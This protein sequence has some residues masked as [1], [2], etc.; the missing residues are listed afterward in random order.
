MAIKNN[1]E[2]IDYLNDTESKSQVLKSILNENDHV[3]AYVLVPVGIVFLIL[4]FS[5]VKPTYFIIIFPFCHC[6]V[7]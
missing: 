2:I 7:L 4:V 3:L 6:Y 1:S 5:S